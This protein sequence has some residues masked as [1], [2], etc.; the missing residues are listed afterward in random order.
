MNIIRIEEKASTPSIKMGQL[1]TY[2]DNVYIVAKKNENPEGCL[3]NL[4]NGNL[5]SEEPIHITLKDLEWKLF[6]GSVTIIVE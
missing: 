3:I 2:G 6:K 1:Y 4:A 5:W